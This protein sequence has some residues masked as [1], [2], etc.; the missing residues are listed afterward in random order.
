MLERIGAENALLDRLH[1][2]ARRRDNAVALGRRQ[3]AGKGLVVVDRLRDQDTASREG[4]DGADAL[5]GHMGQRDALEVALADDVLGV[6]TRV[7][8]YIRV[9]GV[10]LVNDALG[11]A[12]G[13]A[14]V[15]VADISVEVG[16]T[17][18]QRDVARLARLS[19]LVELDEVDALDLVEVHQAVHDLLDV[20]DLLHLLGHLGGVHEQSLAL[21]GEEIV[22]VHDDDGVDGALL[23]MIDKVRQEGVQGDDD[24]RVLLGGIC[25]K[26]M[27][28]IQEVDVIADRVQKV[29]RKQQH[30]ILNADGQTKGDD[31]A[32]LYAC[33]FQSARIS[34]A[35]TGEI[36]VSDR[37]TVVVDRF[38]IKVVLVKGHD[39]IENIHVIDLETVD[40]AIDLCPF[41]EFS[42]D[43]ACVHA[44]NFAHEFSPFLL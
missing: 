25:L 44:C 6:Q 37:R 18:R 10:L 36:A 3:I 23:Q 41:R 11:L 5:A 35:K 27:L 42:L 15:V 33:H 34:V 17:V 30:G 14:G 31:V 21:L 29:D 1:V 22:E 43:F 38:A 26:I 13:A 8:L 12:G 40:L 2:E 4:H 24:V 19:Q 9:E 28:E 20:K 39:I 7:H 32:F 16:R